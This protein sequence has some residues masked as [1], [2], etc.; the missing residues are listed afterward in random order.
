LKRQDPSR[1][2]GLD[3]RKEPGHE[4]MANQG[5]RNGWRSLYSF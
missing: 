3:I 2:E 1:N 5:K 4:I